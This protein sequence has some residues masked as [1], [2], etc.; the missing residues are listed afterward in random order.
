MPVILTTNTKPTSAL[1]LFLGVL[2]RMLPGV[3]N[4]RLE[5]VSIL[6]TLKL[7]TNTNALIKPTPK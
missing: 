4:V 6:M 2:L 3:L 7:L 1:I 5:R